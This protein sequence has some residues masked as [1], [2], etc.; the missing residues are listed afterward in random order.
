MLI[1]F[2]SRTLRVLGEFNCNC[3][4]V[5]NKTSKNT[6]G[7]NYLTERF[8]W[9]MK[10]KELFHTKHCDAIKSNSINCGFNLAPRSLQQSY[11]RERHVMSARVQDCNLDLSSA[12]AFTAK[13]PALG[14]I[15]PQGQRGA[16]RNK[17]IVFVFFL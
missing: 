2:F 12:H 16:F 6:D 13:F 7:I 8:S 3:F 17:Y 14:N 9:F 10:N 11:R 4:T 1:F 15:V 5:N